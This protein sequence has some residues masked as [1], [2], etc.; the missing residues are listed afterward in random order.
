MCLLN[1]KEGTEATGEGVG[2]ERKTIMI[3]FSCFV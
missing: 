3:E 1:G 2:G